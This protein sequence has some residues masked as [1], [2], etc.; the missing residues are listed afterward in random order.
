VSRRDLPPGAGPG[1]RLHHFGG[2]A[3]IWAASFLRG[4][5]MLGVR[6][7]AFD[8]EGRVFLIRH[9]YLPG[10]HLPGGGV[11]PGETVTDALARELDEEAGL[12]ALE[13]PVLHGLFFNRR[14][15]RRD[16]VA[17]FVVRRS[18]PTGSAMPRLEI[19]ERGFFAPDALPEGTG[20]A[21]R[22]RLD[23][24]AGRVPIDPHW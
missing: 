8:A 10:W 24:I 15:S 13:P 14:V 5:L 19:R 21:T 22:A 17:V 12:A 7:V 1:A 16:H 4:R 11:E 18:R 2:N 3:L 23:E 6:L 9:S 20:R